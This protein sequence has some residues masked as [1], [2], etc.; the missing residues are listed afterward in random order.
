VGSQYENVDSEQIES[1]HN[2]VTRSHGSETPSNYLNQA[3]LATI[4]NIILQVLL[5]S[6]QGFLNRVKSL[7][8]ACSC[9][10]YNHGNTKKPIG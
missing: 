1:Q 10:F 7:V 5:L 9:T 2:F 4:I 8:S 3:S 6:L